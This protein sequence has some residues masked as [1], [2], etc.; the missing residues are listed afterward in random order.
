VARKKKE[1]KD[2]HYYEY[3]A[4]VIPPDAM[5]GIE[6]KD[7]EGNMLITTDRLHS[8]GKREAKL[9]LSS[10]VGTIGGWCAMHYYASIQC[11]FHAQIKGNPNSSRGGYLGRKAP[12]NVSNTLLR[13][14][15]QRPVIAG[16]EDVSGNAIGKPGD[17]TYRFNTKQEAHDAGLELFRKRFGPGWVLILDDAVDGNEEC[18]KVIA[19]T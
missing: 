7:D 1:L 13:L 18:D 2:W 16:E 11:D 4:D 14:T 10:Y 12:A 6:W 3:N 5:L 8:S 19:E 9:Y 15:A 17:L